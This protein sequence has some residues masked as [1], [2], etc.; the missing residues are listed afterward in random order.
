MSGELEAPSLIDIAYSNIK[1]DIAED[2]LKAGSKIIIRELSE[3]YNISGTPIKQALNR[4]VMENLV[5]SVPRRGMRVKKV[6]WAEISDILD[7]RL[8]MDLYY[9]KTVILTL[10]NNAE[11][12]KRFLDNINENLD[13]AK[14]STNL[15][16]YQRVYRLDQEFH[17][18]YIRCSGNSKAIQVYG[19]LN[20]HSYSTYLYN[21]QPRA[22]TIE[23][24]LE[25]REIFESL[26]QG[27]EEQ[28]RKYLELHSKNA[29]EIIYH[30]LKTT[31]SI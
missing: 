4:L 17:G 14:N 9:V 20:T 12:Q 15:I 19:S 24:V 29:R 25:H 26:C 13:Y 27:D 5:E 30:T 11:L 16:E 2:H 10:D 6:S 8:M 1:N 3:R 22:K 23:G 28:A 7:F 31:C 18:L 21:K